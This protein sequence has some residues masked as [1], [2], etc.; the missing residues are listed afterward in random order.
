[1]FPK[2]F[3]ALALVPGLTFQV[4]GQALVAP[5]IGVAGTTAQG[6]VQEPSDN[7]PCGA[8]V[9]IAQTLAASTPIVAAADGSFTA[10]VTNFNRYAATLCYTFISVL[11]VIMFSAVLMDLVKSLLL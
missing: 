3:F 4:S 5:P 2:I 1:M 9:D 7:A 11:I 6:D 10:T 8:G